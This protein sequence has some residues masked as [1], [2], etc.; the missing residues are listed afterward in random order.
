MIKHI[1]PYKAVGHWLAE[2]HFASVLAS[3]EKKQNY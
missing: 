2:V 1:A 3:L